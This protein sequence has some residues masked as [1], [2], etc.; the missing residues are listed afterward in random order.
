MVYR[1]HPN[2]IK[3][4]NLLL[5]LLFKEKEMWFL[6]VA[7]QMCFPQVIGNT[8]QIGWW[9]NDLTALPV[10]TGFFQVALNFF[11]S[12]ASASVCIVKY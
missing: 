6:L 4:C 9:V 3:A 1:E 5:I 12:K 8:C 10:S 7:M 11:L 2:A